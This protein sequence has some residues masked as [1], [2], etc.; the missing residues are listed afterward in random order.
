[1]NNGRFLDLNIGTLSTCRLII[2]DMV[3]GKKYI[4]LCNCKILREIDRYICIYK[5][6]FIHS[7]KFPMK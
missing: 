1:M 7:I 3:K 2:P 6:K 4:T 5:P